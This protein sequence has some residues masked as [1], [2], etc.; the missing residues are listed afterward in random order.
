MKASTSV[1][2]K[3]ECIIVCLALI[4]LA[5]QWHNKDWHSA[6]FI[7]GWLVLLL[8]VPLLWYAAAAAFKS[9]W[10]GVRR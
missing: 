7:F 5:V 2:L 6:L 9:W 8:N 4:G 1:F 10:N 3:Y